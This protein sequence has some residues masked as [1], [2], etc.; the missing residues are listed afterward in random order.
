M[1]KVVEIHPKYKN[2]ILALRTLM[3]RKGL[4]LIE[5]S[6]SPCELVI[7]FNSEVNSEEF[8]GKL[9]ICREEA[10]K[11]IVLL[12]KRIKALTVL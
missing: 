9:K 12:Q 7:D 4:K 5:S 10:P 8:Q 11:S 1:K 6:D 3:Q 2:G